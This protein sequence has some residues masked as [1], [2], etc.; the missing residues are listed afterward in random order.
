MENNESISPINEGEVNEAVD[1]YYDKYSEAFDVIESKSDVSK[2]QSIDPYFLY[3]MGQ[4]LDQFE[5]YSGF[6]E[7]AGTASDLGKIPDLALGIVSLFYGSSPISVIAGVQPIFDEIGTVY[8][9]QV[10]AKTTKGNVTAGDVLTNPLNAPAVDP[11]GFSGDTVI[12]DIGPIVA[13]TLSY[14]G[15]ITNVPLRKYKVSVS[16]DVGGTVLTA[17]DDGNG[18]LEGF[19]L[20][21]TVNYATGA[22]TVDFANDPAAGAGNPINV[23]YSTDYEGAADIPEVGDQLVPKAIK[24]RTFVLKNSYG[25][26]QSFIMQQRF[27]KSLD[28]GSTKTLVGAINNEVVG[29]AISLLNANAVGNVNFSKTPPSGV[30]FTEHKQTIKDVMADSEAVMIGNAGRGII[31]VHVV[32]RNAAAILKTLPGFVKISESVNIGPHILGSLDGTPVIRVPSSAMLDP[33]TI[34][35]L[36]KGD[37]FDAPLV[38]SPFMPLVSTAAM[39]NGVNPLSQQKAVAMMAGVDAMTPNLV[40]K[41]TITP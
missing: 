34:L 38:Y 17:K 26:L 31:N 15:T 1:G 7:A 23:T 11:A 29:L 5:R 40:T 13:L 12:Q 4:Q 24:A 19:D 27:G 14:A 35:N 32:G 16:A 3:V 36:Y 39:P 22:I 20:Q 33:D 2:I 9:R 8:H 6:C 30:G 28:S 21:G 25:M 41:V 37:N 18:K 10:I